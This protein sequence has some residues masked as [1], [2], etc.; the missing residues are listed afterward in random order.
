MKNMI[1]SLENLKVEQRTAPREGTLTTLVDNEQMHDK[2]KLFARITLNPGSKTAYHKH[3]NDFEVYYLVS[4]SGVLNDN[5]ILK[6]VKAGDVIFTDDGES[7]SLENTGDT[8]LD[9][10]ALVLTR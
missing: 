10:I 2:S 4:G 6:E 5:G 8:V 9:F 7:H 3:E 1:F